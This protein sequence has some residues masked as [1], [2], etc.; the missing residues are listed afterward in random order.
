M[1]GTIY[2]PSQLL[3]ATASAIVALVIGIAMFYKY[4]DKFILHM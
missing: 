4:Q 3:F 2:D 1:D